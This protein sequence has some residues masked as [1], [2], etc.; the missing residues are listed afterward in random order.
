MALTQ[1]LSIYTSDSA[2]ADLRN[3]IVGVFENIGKTAI[4]QKLKSRNFTENA[5]SFS[6]K[7]FANATVS[8]YGTA[9]TAGKGNK[10]IAPPVV[11][12]LNQ[13]KEIVEEVNFFDAQSFTSENFNAFINRRKMNISLSVQRDLDKA[14]FAAVK[15]GGTAANVEIDTAAKLVP[16]FESAILK[17]ETTA[18]N[19]VDGVERQYMALVLSPELYG[20]VKTELNDCYNFAGTVADEVF[21]GINGVATFSSNHLPTGADYELIVMDSVAQPVMLT[22]VGVEKIQLSNEYAAEVFFRYGTQ[23]LAPELALYGAKKSS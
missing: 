3:V 20:L 12:N 19:Y 8:D 18:N 1:A 7:R 17:L 5:G 21:K 10:I 11:V 6:F 4:S 22:D 2:K 9:R 14:F 13:N 23:V 15:A 16:Q